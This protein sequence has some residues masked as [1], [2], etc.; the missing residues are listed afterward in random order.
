MTKKTAVKI[1]MRNAL[2][3]VEHYQDMMAQSQHNVVACENNRR[4]LYKYQGILT[5]LTIEYNKLMVFMQTMGHSVSESM[6]NKNM[7][8]WLSSFDNNLSF[9]VISITQKASYPYITILIH[10]TV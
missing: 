4:R 3:K 8:T 5:A 7:E 9:K 10:Y 1:R 6:L 2:E